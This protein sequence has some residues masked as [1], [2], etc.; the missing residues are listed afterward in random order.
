MQQLS[1]LHHP[2]S[3]YSQHVLA[4]KESKLQKKV[5]EAA[6]ALQNKLTNF[7]VFVLQEVVT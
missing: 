6:T 4:V 1:V 7:V 5:I 3:I 2:G